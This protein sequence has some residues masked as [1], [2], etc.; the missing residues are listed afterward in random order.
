[1]IARWESL[2]TS[3]SAETVDAAT[4][5]CGFDLDWHLAP[6]DADSERVLAEQLRRSPADRV[7]SVVNLAALRPGA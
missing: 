7:A 5:A 2:A 3:P 6:R 1:M 4:R